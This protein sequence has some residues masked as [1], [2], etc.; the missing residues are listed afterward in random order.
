MQRISDLNAL[1]QS[2]FDELYHHQIKGQI[3]SDPEVIKNI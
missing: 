2:L 1:A 3:N